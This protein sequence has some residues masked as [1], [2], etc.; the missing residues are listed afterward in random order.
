MKEGSN[1]GGQTSKEYE[2]IR[3]TEKECL[4]HHLLHTVKQ[5]NGDV[6]FKQVY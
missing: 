3:P 6:A 2:V 4:N 5:V 1:E